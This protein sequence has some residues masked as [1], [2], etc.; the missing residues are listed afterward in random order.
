MIKSDKYKLREFYLKKR[1]SLNHAEIYKNNQKICKNIKSLPQIT[2][3][4]T[5]ACYLTV[6]NEPNVQE[7]IDYLLK[8]KK[9]VVVP[10]FFENLGKY[11]FVRLS[12][13]DN[14]K[15]GSYKIPQPSKLLPVDSNN[16]DLVLIP[17]LA[18]TKNGLRLGYGK[19]VYDR[20]LINIKTLKIAVAY[21]F[22]IIDYLE[23]ES[24]DLK[25]DFIIT[26]QRVFTTHNI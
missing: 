9:S 25:V 2:N 23:G 11:R 21:D 19:G 24:H 1:L 17:G 22:Q 8:V 4:N 3:E 14:L 5:I 16:I 6:N 13:L 10:A 18:F 26:E 20:L 15:I 7:V 12:T